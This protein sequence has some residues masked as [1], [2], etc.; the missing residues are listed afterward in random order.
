MGSIASTFLRGLGVVVPVGL[1][2]WIV[3]WLVIS[4]ETVLRS[5]FEF[6][7]P[8]DYYFPG[9]GFALGIAV[10]YGT[11]VLV[12]V[13]II[14]QVFEWFDGLLARIPLVK[15]VYNAISDLSLIHI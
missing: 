2:I 14:R 13:F 5:V 12:Q 1:T 6:L 11:G 9:L 4:I 15:T 8:A 10:I 7:L 3:M